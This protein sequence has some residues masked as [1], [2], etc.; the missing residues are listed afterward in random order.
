MINLNQLRL[1]CRLVQLELAERVLIS[2]LLNQLLYSS[3]ANNMP[4]HKLNTDNAIAENT[5][6]IIAKVLLQLNL[7]R[8]FCSVLTSKFFY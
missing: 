5:I 1:I 4:T 2:Y 6:K 8:S 7:F 3:L